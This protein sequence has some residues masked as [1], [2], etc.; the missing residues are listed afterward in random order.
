MFRSARGYSVYVVAT[1]VTAVACSHKR[2]AIAPSQTPAEPQAEVSPRTNTEDPNREASDR[3][4]ATRD[5]AERERAA[6]NAE[7]LRLL[8][9]NIYFEF[10]RFDLSSE[11]RDI[12]DRKLAVLRG[13]PTLEI[14]VVGHADERG[15]DEYNLALGHRRAEAAKRYLTQRGIDG[16]RIQ[17]A[18]V[19][20]EQPQCFEHRETC[21]ERNR[22]DE[23]QVTSGVASA[24]R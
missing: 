21:W 11:A 7:R 16:G 14:S 13:D 1:L 10:D 3:D 5:A 4:R 9:A 23:F 24:P 18:S 20:E 15:S 2:P 6:R 8:Q 22:R 17:T 19:G 12:L